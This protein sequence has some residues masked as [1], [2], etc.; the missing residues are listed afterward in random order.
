MEAITFKPGRRWLKLKGQ[1]KRAKTVFFSNEHF[2][3]L[4]ND[5]K[6]MN[7]SQNLL[8]NQIVSDYYIRQ[9][10]VTELM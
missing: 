8:I 3:R 5:S 9:D 6:R 2:E 1:A 7:I 4:I 10:E